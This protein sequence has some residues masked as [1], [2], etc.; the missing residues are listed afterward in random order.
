MTTL[1]MEAMADLVRAALAES[2]SVQMNLTV[3]EDCSAKVAEIAERL[4]WTKRR[5]VE[6]AILG[7]FVSLGDEV[8]QQSA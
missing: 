5:V 4:N 2:S 7:L 8:A 3:S 6:T 1:D